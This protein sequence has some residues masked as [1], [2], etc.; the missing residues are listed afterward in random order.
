MPANTMPSPKRKGNDSKS[1]QGQMLDVCV[2]KM[3]AL[4]AK[5][6]HL[7]A[8]VAELQS[9]IQ[10]K[11]GSVKTNIP[12]Q[13]KVAVFDTS[14]KQKV[15]SPVKSTVLQEKNGSVK[16][17]IP[18]QPKAAVPDNSKTKVKSSVKSPML[19]EKNGSVKT[20]IPDQSK[21]AVPDS[22]K[23]QNVKSPV[24]SAV[25]QEN[26]KPQSVSKKEKHDTPTKILIPQQRTDMLV[27]LTPMRENFQA[28]PVKHPKYKKVNIASSCAFVKVIGPKGA[29]EAGTISTAVDHIAP[30]QLDIDAEDASI[31]ISSSLIEDPV[32]GIAAKAQVA[33]PDILEMGVVFRPN[34]IVPESLQFGHVMDAMLLPPAIVD[35]LDDPNEMPP[36]LYYMTWKYHSCGADGFEQFQCMEADFDQKDRIMKVY[37]QILGHRQ[38]VQVWFMTDTEAVEE[39]FE[40]LRAR[41][42]RVV[43]REWSPCSG[44]DGKQEKYCLNMAGKNRKGVMQFLQQSAP[45]S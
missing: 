2:M 33:D 6:E 24:E 20:N 8:Q 32:E 18:Q 17:N 43:G 21:T 5:V 37:R 13:S 45:P 15:K 11:N 12:D 31:W 29:I 27:D 40:C 41:C 34:H 35:R 44:H 7:E 42:Y 26:S 14:K 30:L 1:M 16:T 28:P 10:E 19:Q 39:S 23:A 3:A 25:L 9:R 4:E 36:N 22:S 38:T